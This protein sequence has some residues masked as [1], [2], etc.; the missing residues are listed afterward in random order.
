[1]ML[2][3]S[4]ARPRVLLVRPGA[5]EFD[6]QGRIK[7]SLDMPLSDHGKQQVSALAEEL[8]SIRLKTIYSAPAESAVYTAE[9]LAKPRDLKVKVVDGLRNVDHGLWH[10]KL[11]EE[12]KRNQPKVYRC[13]IDSP[14]EVC[15]PNGE[16]IRDARARVL[17][18]L[19]KL[20]RKGRDEVIAL[21]IPDPM[22]TVVQSVLSGDELCDLWKS[23]T[24]HG[25]WQ[26]IEP[27]F[28]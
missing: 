16:S 21:V 5:T 19:R 8:A 4:P 2:V 12:V 26:L 25:D 6:D 13:G 24:D 14:D 10:G 20:V 28:S 9:R 27:N 3:R 1:M 22:A 15:P 17:K 11:I 7:G 18:S 23:E